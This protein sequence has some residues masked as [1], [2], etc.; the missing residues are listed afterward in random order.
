MNDI[1][2]RSDV[3]ADDARAVRDIVSST[4]FFYEEEIAVAVELV[5]ERLNKGEVSGYHFLFVESSGRTVGYACFGP[6]P[7]TQASWDLYWIAVH[8]D[9]RGKGIGKT[10]LA[11]SEETIRA[12]GGRRIYIETASRELYAPTRAFYL[13][14]GYVMEALLQ[15]FYA[16][17]DSKCIFVKVI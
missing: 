6:T 4:G 13:A 1:I 15:D 8:P 12:A 5:D 7:C 14:C 3:R 10:L 9:F 17:G 2:L 11:A 16:P